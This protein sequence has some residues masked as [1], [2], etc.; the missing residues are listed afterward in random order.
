MPRTQQTTTP[1]GQEHLKKVKGWKTETRKCSRKAKGSANSK[2]KRRHT[3]SFKVKE[4]ICCLWDGLKSNEKGYEFYEEKLNGA[5]PVEL[6]DNVYLRV[7]NGWAFVNDEGRLITPKEKNLTDTGAYIIGWTTTLSG[8]WR[9]VQRIMSGYWPPKENCILSASGSVWCM[10]AVVLLVPVGEIFAK[11]V[12]NPIM[13]FVGVWVS[14]ADMK[15]NYLLQNPVTE[16][17]EI[18]SSVLYEMDLEEYMWEDTQFGACHPDW[19]SPWVSHMTRMELQLPATHNDDD[20]SY[21]KEE[22]LGV[23]ETESIDQ[24]DLVDY[25][26]GTSWCGGDPYGPQPTWI[27][28]LTKQAGALSTQ[29]VNP[30]PAHTGTDGTLSGTGVATNTDANTNANTNAGID[31]AQDEADTDADANA[32]A[33]VEA[34]ANANAD[35]PGDKGGPTAVDVSG[36]TPGPSHNETG[37]ANKAPSCNPHAVRQL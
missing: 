6:K 28:A 18:W 10:E 36:S 32:E 27:P 9:R 2:A 5:L 13:D 12:K 8:G 33:D 20:E 30:S 37:Q 1:H 3:A 24:D 16:Y 22:P 29:N 35:A 23:S 26:T 19:M 34:D 21:K 25:P 11:Q 17:E 4:D 15:G 14:S 7:M 31:G